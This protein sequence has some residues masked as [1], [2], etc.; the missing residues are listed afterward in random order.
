MSDLI[1][2]QVALDAIDNERK[3]LLSM[4]MWDAEHIVVHYAR[5]II[6]KMPAVTPA[7]KTGHWIETDNYDPCWY[8]CSECHGRTDDKSDYCPNCGSKMFGISEQVTSG[9]ERK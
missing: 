1:E 4:G 7:E 6:E 3:F 5:R 9:K 8:M 2:R